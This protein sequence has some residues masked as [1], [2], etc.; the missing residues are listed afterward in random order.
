MLH[1]ARKVIASAASPPVHAAGRR[2]IE[3]GELRVLFVWSP[4]DPV[5]PFAHADRY[6]AALAERTSRGIDDCYSFTPEDQP[7]RLADAIAAFAG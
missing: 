4:E 5:F 3:T 2:L 6:A 1:D 7:R